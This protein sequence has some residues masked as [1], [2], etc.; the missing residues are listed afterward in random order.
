[1][2][3]A[4]MGRELEEIRT[5]ARGQATQIRPRALRDAANLVDRVSDVAR[6]SGAAA[7]GAGSDRRHGRGAGCRGGAAAA[8]PNG[9]VEAATTG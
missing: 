7:A 8:S 2:P 5:Q 6:L 1:M 4:A 9:H 3:L